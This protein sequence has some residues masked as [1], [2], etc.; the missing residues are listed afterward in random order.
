MVAQGLLKMKYTDGSV[1]LHFS[2]KKKQA[3][4]VG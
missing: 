2:Q 1:K 3:N 4:I